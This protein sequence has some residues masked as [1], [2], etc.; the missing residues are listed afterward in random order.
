[1]WH[2]EAGDRAMTTAEWE[3]FRVGLAEL[4]GALEEDLVYGTNETETGVTAFDR[5]TIEQKLALLADVAQALHDPAVPMC[6]LTAA[7][8]GA[9][10]AVFGVIESLVRDEMRSRN[11]TRMRSRLL[12]VAAESAERDET[13]D[14]P[15]LTSRKYADWSLLLECFEQTVLWDDDW[16]AEDHY[17]DLP[18]TEARARM[19]LMG[20]DPDYFLAIPREPNAAELKAARAT[21]S[22]LLSAPAF[23]AS[24]ATAA[25]SD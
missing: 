20:I 19:Q 6:D 17:L 11:E 23:T 21:L 12:A 1:M 4:V 3:L 14:L 13:D 15:K 16:A 2:M 22:R 24:S 7:S 5:L 18:P 9:V 25:K 10:A 8:E